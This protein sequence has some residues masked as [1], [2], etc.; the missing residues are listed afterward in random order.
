MYELLA[1]T[2]PY[3]GYPAEVLI[4]KVGNEFRQNLDKIEGPKQL[5]VFK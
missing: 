1:G 3:A 5:K 4:Y 2:W